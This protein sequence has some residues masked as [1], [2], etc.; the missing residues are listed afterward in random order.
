MVRKRLLNQIKSI[1]AKKT[2]FILNVKFLTMKKS[3]SFYSNKT[4]GLMMRSI[5]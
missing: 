3:R 2:H 1:S 5:T 4:L